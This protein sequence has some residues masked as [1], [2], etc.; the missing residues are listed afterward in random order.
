MLHNCP[1]TKKRF[2]KFSLGSVRNCRRPEAR[3]RELSEHAGGVAVGAVTP[4]RYI[5]HSKS[6]AAT[7]RR[8]GCLPPRLFNS[9]QSVKV[10]VRFPCTCAF[11]V[12]RAALCYSWLVSNPKPP[13]PPPREKTPQ[14]PN[15]MKGPMTDFVFQTFKQSVLAYNV[16]KKQKQKRKLPLY[17]STSPR[18]WSQTVIRYRGK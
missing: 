8:T 6:R 13:Q 17:V 5:V 7:N 4:W 9:S 10:P 16:L 14:I 12:K 1:C 11:P 2:V 3:A 18:I 15:G